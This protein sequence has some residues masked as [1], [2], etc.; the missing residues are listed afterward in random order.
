MPTITKKS[1][2]PKRKPGPIARRL[3]TPIIK[4]GGKKKKK[5]DTRKPNPHSKAFKHLKKM[6]RK[7][8]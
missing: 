7:G 5:E 4:L 3:V 8:T 2:R 1:R 6:T